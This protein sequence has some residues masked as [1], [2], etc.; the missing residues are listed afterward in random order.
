[1]MQR[2]ERIYT[3]DLIKDMKTYCVKIALHIALYKKQVDYY[4]WTA[5]EIIMNELTLISPSI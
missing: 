3:L 2:A 1:M 4:N 5:Y